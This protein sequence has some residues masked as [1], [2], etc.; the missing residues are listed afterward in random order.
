MRARAFVHGDRQG[1]GFDQTRLPVVGVALALLALPGL[2]LLAG[3]VG[4][5]LWCRADHAL[6]WRRADH[7]LLRRRA[8]HALLRRR[9]D[10]ALLRRR[11]DHALLRRRADHALLRRRADHALLAVIPHFIPAPGLLVARITGAAVPS[12]IHGKWRSPGH[13]SSVPVVP[14]FV[15]ALPVVAP[16]VAPARRR[17]A[18]PAHEVGRR[19]P[20]VAARNA[21]HVD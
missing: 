13:A 17:F 20:I 16:V 4:L 18:A 3:L 8:D 5:G 15:P 21:E 10:H 1:T 19:L 12:L 14:A 9:A 7:A 6:L 2:R 11:A